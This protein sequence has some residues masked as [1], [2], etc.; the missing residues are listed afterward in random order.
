MRQAETRGRQYAH[1][2]GLINSSLAAG[3]AQGAVLDRGI[4]L[5]KADV[6]DEFQAF[7][8]GLDMAK[9][10]ADANYRNRVLEQEKELTTERLMFDR[11]RFESD[12]GYRNRVLAQ[13]KE[14]AEKRLDFD[15]DRFRSDENYRRDVLEQEK[16]LTTER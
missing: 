4:D 1:Q 14:L 2:R 12:E 13:E 15:A 10:E 11:N 9:F 16:E 6:A 7:Y 5:G 3:A 8:A